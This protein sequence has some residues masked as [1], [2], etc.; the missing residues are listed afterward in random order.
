MSVNEITTY[1]ANHNNTNTN[2]TVT[3]VPNTNTLTEVLWRKE[4]GKMAII[5]AV[6][7]LSNYGMIAE[8]REIWILMRLRNM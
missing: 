3:S 4:F 8:A 6:Q 1:W 7:E 2:P 5:V